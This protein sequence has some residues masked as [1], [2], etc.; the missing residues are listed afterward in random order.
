MRESRI[1]VDSSFTD[2]SNPNVNPLADSMLL[3]NC[4]LAEF[5]YQ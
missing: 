2:P 4:Q 1:A 3:M 5:P